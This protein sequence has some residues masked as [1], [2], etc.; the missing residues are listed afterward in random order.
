M[1]GYHLTVSDRLDRILGLC[2]GE[3]PSLRL[4]HKQQVWWMRVA[5]ALLRPFVPDFMTRYTTVMFGTV[6]LPCPA[7]EMVRDELASILAHELVHLRDQRRFHVWFYVSYAL[8]LP[9]GR[10]MRARWELR[11]YAVDMLL[12][13]E[14]GGAADARRVAARLVKVFAGPAYLWMWCPTRSARRYLEP[15]VE[16]VCRGDLDGV[17]PY[18]DVLRAWRARDG[19]GV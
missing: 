12:A 15:V 2:R 7:G 3:S 19:R 8:V 6:Y 16:A 13:R 17:E 5:G 10:T 1:T 4:V 18:C 14:R 9:V 11:A